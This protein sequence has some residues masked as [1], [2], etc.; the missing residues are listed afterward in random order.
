MSIT[1]Q[2]KSHVTAQSPVV[3]LYCANCWRDEI[4][5]PR[6]RSEALVACFTI[7]TLGLYYFLRTYR[8]CT[9]GNLRLRAGRATKD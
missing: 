6:Q 4:H 8:C 1:T 7:L 5:R 3:E 9:C 2:N